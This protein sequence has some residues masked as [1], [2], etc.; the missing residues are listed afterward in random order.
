MT[1]NSRTDQIITLALKIDEYLKTVKKSLSYDGD[2]ESKFENHYWEILTQ[3]ET[4]NWQIHNLA[5]D[6]EQENISLEQ[7]STEF[8]D[9]QKKR[10]QSN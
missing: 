2:L 10:Q 9:E 8:S 3:A 6:I 5:T 1:E 4:L 7:L